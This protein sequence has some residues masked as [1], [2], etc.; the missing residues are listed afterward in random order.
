M[1]LIYQPPRPGLRSRSDGPFE[2][3]QD[4]PN[5]L[6]IVVECV[7]GSAAYGSLQTKKGRFHPRIPRHPGR[8]DS[9]YCTPEMGLIAFPSASRASVF[10]HHPRSRKPRAR[11]SIS[12]VSSTSIVG[13]F[14]SSSGMSVLL[15]IAP[16][17]AAISGV[18]IAQSNATTTRSK[19][20]VS[21]LTFRWFFSRL[22]PGPNRRMMSNHE[23][24]SRAYNQ[25]A[26]KPATG[27]T[28]VTKSPS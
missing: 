8:I 16:P 23:R 12:V 25:F 3:R 14:A 21:S 11:I 7:D 27:G 17:L 4:R 2:R 26:E 5:R 19:L 10:W 22:R 15:P 20:S 9:P 1:E 6:L 24:R 28:S 13:Q 18:A